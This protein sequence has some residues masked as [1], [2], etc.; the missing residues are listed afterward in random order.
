MSE[1]CNY[2][3]EAKNISK[4]FP[5]VK[6]LSTVNL[7]VRKGVVHALMGENG[8]GK[9]TLMKIL[10]G[11][12]HPDEED[13]FLRGKRVI[14]QTTEDALKAGISMIHQELSPVPHMSVAENI[15]LGRE[16]LRMGSFVDKRAMN[17]NAK[18]LLKELE[19]PIDPSLKMIDLSVAQ[20]QMVEIAKA[21]SYN[22]DLIIMDE[23][24]S[25]ITESEV[26]HLFTMIRGLV[27]K[28][29]SVIFITHKLDEVYKI[30]DEIT[31]YRDGSYVGCG[32]TKDI[33]RE[34]LVTMMVG[35]EVKHLFPKQDVPIGD[36]VLSVKNLSR[37]GIFENVSFDLRKGEILGFAGLV[38]SGR[39]EVL[40]C[41]FGVSCKT[42]GEVFLRNERI[43]IDNPRDAIRHRMALLTEDRK[44]TGLYLSLSVSD[45]I[46]MA[47]IQHFL[48]AGLV[49]KKR[50]IKTISRKQRELLNIKTPHLQQLVSKLSEGNQQKVLVARW[51]LMDPDILILDEPTR[52]IDVGAKSEIHKIMVGLANQGKSIV[53]ISSE[54][55]EVLGMSDR[56]IVMHGG[57]KSGELLRAEA[58]QEKILHLATGESL[59]TFDEGRYKLSEV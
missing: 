2:I 30:T 5:G 9:S 28:G 31:V 57:Q 26:E 59:E 27:A 21:I 54:L 58:T 38:G 44:S 8:A 22:A 35:R 19:I 24:T 40:E 4:S 10:I 42:G 39:T 33:S 16:P 32:K 47:D 46:I 23:P 17:E 3:L 20:T 34:A 14:F 45:N 1:D 52:G 50:D 12:Y 41:L 48:R 53:M 7:Q 6:A 15:Y 18:K 51:L 11:I 37:K 36:V 49:L 29:V 25:T 43:T 13:L 56:I 55:P